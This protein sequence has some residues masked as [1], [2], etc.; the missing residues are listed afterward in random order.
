ML[1]EGIESSLAIAGGCD[2]SRKYLHLGLVD[3]S[4]IYKCF[5]STADGGPN[6]PRHFSGMNPQVTLEQAWQ[7]SRAGVHGSVVTS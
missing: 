3:I 5:D 1:Y 6:I 7:N 4:F 2:D